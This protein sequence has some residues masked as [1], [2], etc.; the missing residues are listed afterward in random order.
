MHLSQFETDEVK[1]GLKSQ[2]L[3]FI[4]NC[5]TAG[6]SLQERKMFTL[7]EEKAMLIWAATMLQP[8][9][10]LSFLVTWTVCMATFARGQSI[11]QATVNQLRV[12][13]AHGPY[14]DEEVQH[15]RQHTISKLLLPI[16]T[17][18]TCNRKGEA[19]YEQGMWPHKE[20][21][22]NPELMIG[23]RLAYR[24]R[25]TSSVSFSFKVGDYKKKHFWR[26]FPL[27]S[28][29]KL[30]SQ[31]DVFTKAAKATNT[32]W[33]K[34]TH[35]RSAGID[36]VTFHGELY[37]P[38]VAPVSNHGS[39]SSNF[40]RYESKFPKEVMAACAGFKKGELYFVPGEFAEVASP[41]LNDPTT[42]AMILFGPEYSRRKSESEGPGGDNGPEAK[43]F[44]EQ[45]VPFFAQ[46]HIINGHYW[47]EHFPLHPVSEDLLS[48]KIPGFVSYEAFANEMR[49]R[50]EQV[51]IDDLPQVR[52]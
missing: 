30:S 35:L 40:D 36:R 10:G 22:R 3:E 46:K 11:R 17:E 47:L 48:L 49:S 38:Q 12:D 18:K 5:R 41:E 28:W 50:V 8:V 23:A 39:R 16:G 9:V 19:Q 26:F 52:P 1:A 29:D 13:E 14:T 32:K 25:R 4:K 42:C 7:G 21:I 15:W 51:T 31:S 43:A 44:L 45:V 2:N 24:L 20:F 27:V 33:S 6:R 34:T 37:E